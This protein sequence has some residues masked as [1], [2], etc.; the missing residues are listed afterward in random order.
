MSDD[1]GI[2]DEF[3]KKYYIECHA[4]PPNVEEDDVDIIG[5]ITPQTDDNIKLLGD[6]VNSIPKDTHPSKSLRKR[7]ADS[8]ATYIDVDC[9]TRSSTTKL[10]KVVK[11]KQEAQD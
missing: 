7:N 10:Q 3:K 5:P 6:E 8:D 1:N 2:I 4:A 11:I 9:Q